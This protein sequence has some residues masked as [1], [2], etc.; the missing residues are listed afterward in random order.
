MSMSSSPLLPTA[1][2]EAKAR[3]EARL[4]Q[5]W[6]PGTKLP[7]I[8]QLAKKLKLG[9][10]SVNLAV[11]QLASEG[12]LV[13]KPGLGTYV[14]A[15]PGEE[16]DRPG[17]QH[18]VNESARPSAGVG[19]RIARKATPRILIYTIVPPPDLLT[20]RLADAVLHRLSEYGITP[21]R[22]PMSDKGVMAQHGMDQADA[23]L[24][25]NPNSIVMFDV[26]PHQ[27]YI[28]VNTGDSSIVMPQTRGDLISLDH[29]Q[30]GLLA[31][32]HLRECG[33]RHVCYLGRQVA[34]NRQQYDYLSSRRHFGFEQGW[35]EPLPA[36]R[37]LYGMSYG[38]GSGAMAAS[39][40]AKLSPRP[41]AIF[42]ASDE[43][44]VGFVKGAMGLGLLPQR[45]YQIVGFD[46]QQRALDLVTGPLTTILSPVDEM[47]ARG[48][49]LLLD[50]WENPDQRTRHLQL[51]VTLSMGHSTR[52]P[53]TA[54]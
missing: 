22:V 54:S 47:G 32:R 41:D 5:E 53:S 44:A 23:I 24:A 7:P 19:K 42:A 27:I 50:R 3:L 48:V 35:G 46:G 2:N 26:K 45:D 17:P 40:W 39:H 38:E 20:N 25:L 8:R 34:S 52:L 37:L 16:E 9:V 49:D 13:S 29:A 14:L 18:P 12:L 11:Q 33:A 10:G 51:G 6:G 30:G 21:Q 43:L 36:E 1:P 15:R 4:S 31:A 28:E